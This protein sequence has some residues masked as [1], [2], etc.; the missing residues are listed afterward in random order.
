[1]KKIMIFWM[2]SIVVFASSTVTISVIKPVFNSKPIII[3][4][5]GVVIAKNRTVLTAKASGIFHPLYTTMPV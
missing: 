2:V 1:M 3:E 5:D 4:A